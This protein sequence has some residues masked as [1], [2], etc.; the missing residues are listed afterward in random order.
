MLSY[1]IIIY[2]L[3]TSLNVMCDHVS[4]FFCNHNRRCVRVPMR[5]D[6]HDRSINDTQTFYPTNAELLIDHGHLIMAHLT[7]AHGMRNS[8][9]VLAQELDDLCIALYLGTW[10]RFS[11]GVACKRCGLCQ[12]TYQFHSFDKRLLLCLMNCREIIIPTGFE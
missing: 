5:N 4:N 1:H 11:L 2:G 10:N 7:G 8:S 9:D 3:K 12:T 6:R